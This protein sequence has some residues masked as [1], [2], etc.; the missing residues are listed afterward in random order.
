MKA[1][2]NSWYRRA[3][4][5]TFWN[6]PGDEDCPALISFSLD[7]FSY[8]LRPAAYFDYNDKDRWRILQIRLQISR[9]SFVVHIPYRKL[10]DY[11][12]NGKAMLRTR[13]VQAEHDAT[14]KV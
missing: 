10:P 13:R 1:L 2:M 5:Y 4:A 11:V 8:D 3:E 9:R 6:T 14:K 12:P 7:A